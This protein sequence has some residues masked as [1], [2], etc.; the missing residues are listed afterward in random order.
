M[1]DEVVSE[2]TSIYA[3]GDRV[4]RDGSVCVM[5]TS[6]YHTEPSPVTLA[7]GEHHEKN[8]NSYSGLFMRDRMYC[9]GGNY[10]ET[11]TFGRHCI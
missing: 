4:Q 2:R 9:A 5:Q 3:T 10:Y 1:P 6:R 8:I 7:G 11:I